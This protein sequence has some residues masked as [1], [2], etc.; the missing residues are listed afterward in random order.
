MTAKH[1]TGL[2]KSVT[3]QKRWKGKRKKQDARKSSHA[4]VFLKACGEGDKK[5]LLKIH[6]KNI[7]WTETKHKWD[8]ENSFYT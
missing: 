6:I 1:E 8:S 7:S 5:N 4:A 3:I 2:R